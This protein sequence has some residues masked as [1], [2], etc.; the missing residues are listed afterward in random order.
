DVCFV[1]KN[2]QGGTHALAFAFKPFA[3]NG[4]II[5]GL[6]K[7]RAQCLSVDHFIPVAFV[8]F[9]LIDDEEE[10]EIEQRDVFERVSA[11]LDLLA[12]QPFNG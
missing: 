3:S 12:I 7:I 4:L 6:S 8:N 9:E 2:Y 10:R 1:V 5:E 11:F